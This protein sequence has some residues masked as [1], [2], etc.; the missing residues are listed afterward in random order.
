MGKLT[1]SMAIFNSYI[2]LPEGNLCGFWLTCHFWWWWS[3]FLVVFVAKEIPLLML[4][5]NKNDQEH[6]VNPVK[7]SSQHRNRDLV[8][9]VGWGLWSMETDIRIRTCGMWTAHPWRTLSEVRPLKNQ[10]GISKMAFKWWVEPSPSINIDNGDL[11]W[12]PWWYRI[13]SSG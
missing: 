10:E 11:S 13:F 8:E 2:K 5:P 7:P 9:N 6:A 3:R 4:T 12:I 1:I